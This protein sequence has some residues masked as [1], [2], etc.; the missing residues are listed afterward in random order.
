MKKILLGIFVTLFAA[1][2]NAEPI[3][4]TGR[5]LLEDGSNAFRA[6]IYYNNKPVGFAD[7]NGNFS[8]TNIESGATLKVTFMGSDS[9]E[10]IAEPNVGT[11]KLKD[12]KNLLGMAEVYGVAP[13]RTSDII[14]DGMAA[15]HRIVKDGKCYPT[16][17]VDTHK[18]ISN[19]GN[20][21]IEG[22]YKSDDRIVN[23]DG[24][25]C[26]CL[27]SNKCES[28]IGTDCLSEIQSK[29]PNA[30]RAEYQRNRRYADIGT[31]GTIKK[32]CVIT[33]CK[34]GFEP[35]DDGTACECPSDTHIIE[36]SQCTKVSKDC[37]T[38]PDHAKSSYQKLENGK[39]ICYI[40]SCKDGYEPSVD[41]QTVTKP[42]T[43]CICPN[44]GNHVVN[45]TNGKCE[46][47]QGKACTDHNKENVKSAKYI[48]LNSALFCAIS[49]C[50]KNFDLIN[51]NTATQECVCPKD[52]GYEIDAN[53][54]QCIKVAGDCKSDDPNA[55]ETHREFD[56]KANKEICVIDECGN[57][58]KRD[59]KANKCV[60]N[61]DDGMEERDGQCVAVGGD[62]NP[63]PENATSAHREF[64]KGKE[65]CV[66]DACAN[67]FH[68][69]KD[70]TGCDKADL[71]EEQSKEKIKQLQD[72]AQKMKEK[73]Q[74]TE[75]KLIGALG[76]GATG[77]GGMQAMSALA[78]QSADEDIEQEMKAYL[79]TFRCE[80]TPGKQFKGGEMGIEIPGANDLAP[81]YAEYVVLAADL[82]E[83]KDALDMM[84]G[85]ESEVLIDKAT[86]GLYDDVGIGITGGAYTSLARALMDPTGPDAA[87]WAAQKSETAKKLKTGLIV[88]G[89]G[90]LGSMAANLA[91]NSGKD[92]KNRVDE[93]ENYFDNLGNDIEDTIN[94]NAKCPDGTTGKYPDCK[95]TDPNHIMTEGA[96]CEACPSDQKP[97][98]S[99]A[100]CICK[101]ASQTL[102]NGT[103]V[104]NPQCPS[105][106][107]GT[108]PNCR[109][110]GA[111]MVYNEPNNQCIACPSDQ[112]PDTDGRTCKC[113]DASKKLH[114][115]KCIATT[116]TI[117][118]ETSVSNHA[119]FNMGQYKV[120]TEIETKLNELMA[121]PTTAAN[122][123][124]VQKC[125]LTVT[126][127]TD[128]YWSRTTSSDEQAERFNVELSEKRAKAVADVLET[129]IQAQNP[130]ITFTKNTNG[131]G[132]T[133]CICGESNDT[134]Y[135]PATAS[136]ACKNQASG[137]PVKGY[138]SQY[139]PC[140]RVT[141]KIECTGTNTVDTN[142]VTDAIRNA[143]DASDV[144][145]T[146]S[147]GIFGL[148][149]LL[150]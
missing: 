105:N 108:H 141:L 33:K 127:H 84:P 109:C 4:V 147:S 132:S 117:T 31:I 17:C 81:M 48:M 87:A 107:T 79:Q 19:C 52:K 85:I 106:A 83:R 53:T 67:G 47:Q 26:S 101:D 3:T 34:N 138:R 76:M 60:C 58:Y 130:N 148:G 42:G 119:L 20:I 125:T 89:V 150:S 91:V 136:G 43:M 73:E 88:A 103:C 137:T 65:I 63:M 66:V 113:R 40:K 45:A 98:D 36:G 90:A 80:Y 120:T 123:K 135:D 64:K 68:V 50:D 146:G 139:A 126:G 37:D 13:C 121:E 24:V 12:T 54:K 62:C 5:V 57:G 116:I 55:T 115:G 30:M 100:A 61:K 122:L 15:A 14:D 118:D 22:C 149:N 143:T 71:S 21:S 128:P 77:I 7:D 124:K 6:S 41:G 142:N 59:K 18:L 97:D 144:T 104:S 46:E 9:Q 56:K 95:C 129:A 29:E 86:S 25:D 44:D 23:D 112:E 102:V 1:T 39:K 131:I 140:R 8:V 35:N 93:I 133:A 72:N 111:N 94:N 75:N 96:K 10:F 2:V 69:N 70:K 114:Q 11:I 16:R 92:K 134:P 49:K 110:N 28:L 78:E 74:S 32:I 51:K 27:T 38:K 99:G 82:K 145:D